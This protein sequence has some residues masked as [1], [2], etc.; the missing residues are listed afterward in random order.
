MDML[1][2]EEMEGYKI[3][4]K[5]SCLET[6]EKPTR[7]FLRREKQLLINVLIN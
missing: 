7:F 2:N 6:Y 5:V 4:A 1:Y 3:R